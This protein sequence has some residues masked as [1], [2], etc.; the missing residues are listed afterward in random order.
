M[1]RDIFSTSLTL[2]ITFVFKLVL[3]IVVARLF[4]PEGKGL[5][6]AFFLVPEFIAIIG[7]LSLEEACLY[8]L[9][10]KRISKTLLKK[11]F[12]NIIL[13][14]VPILI[15]AGYVYLQLI[16]YHY[17][18]AELALCLSLIPIYLILEI[19]RFSLRGLHDIRTY[20]LSIL[21]EAVV[22]LFFVAALFIQKDVWWFI[23]G[24][25]CG[26]V[27]ALVLVWSKF[28][29]IVKQYSVEGEPVKRSKD[30]YVYGFK[31]HVFKVFNT[32]DAKIAALV[33]S[34]VLT[35]S[36]LGIYSVA[37]TFSLLLHMGL[38]GPVSTVILP[39]LANISESSRIA[40]VG[41]ATRG[42]FL[43]SILF[44]LALILFGEWLIVLIFG[45]SFA[46][47]YW[48]MVVLVIGKVIKSPMATLSCYFKSKGMPEIIAAISMKA[49][50]ISI[51]LS[52]IL[53][54]FYGIMGAAVA[55]VI[56]NLVFVFL[57]VN[58]YRLE[59]GAT[60]AHILLVNRE[61]VDLAV[62][63]LRILKGKITQ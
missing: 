62:V 45:E 4:G 50:P 18:L 2:N 9:A 58:Q 30:V 23:L 44:L 11:V 28:L 26:L 29:S 24:Q 27:L 8:W 17:D 16:D 41:I 38:Q 31:V 43:V 25:S 47:A 32:L 33:I 37:V 6:V 1:L 52:I 14:Q 20:N 13:L 53:I 34:I 57:M 49:A 15:G 35:L 60:L 3:A 10:K 5:V 55:T 12:L 51:V 48:P 21:I 42:M 63:K 56:A 46:V 54:P 22:P 59:T 36:E 19:G 39:Q 7:S 61:D 40:I